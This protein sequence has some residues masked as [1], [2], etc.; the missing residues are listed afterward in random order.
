MIKTIIITDPLGEEKPEGIIEELAGWTKT[1]TD[2]FRVIGHYEY[3]SEE[4]EEKSARADLLLIDYGG[5]A[6]GA[7]DMCASQIRWVCEW[8]KEHPG[9]LVILL[10]MFTAE[11]YFDE[12]DQ[13][14]GE[15]DNIITRYCDPYSGDRDKA[16]AWLNALSISR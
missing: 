2:Q 9:K 14:F 11:I 8:A 10:T 13:E 4:A 15:C 5:M 7:T 3:V 1:A 16:S 12:L 6:L